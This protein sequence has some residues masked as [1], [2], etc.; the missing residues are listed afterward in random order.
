MRATSKKHARRKEGLT[1][2]PPA[3]LVSSKAGTGS[4]RRRGIVKARDVG[5]AAPVLGVT[6]E[7]WVDILSSDELGAVDVGLGTG[8]RCGVNGYR[9]EKQAIQSG[10]KNGALGDS[11]KEISE[12]MVGELELDGENGTVIDKYLSIFTSPMRMKRMK[13]EKECEPACEI[14]QETPPLSVIPPSLLNVEQQHIESDQAVRSLDHPT[15]NRTANYEADE[16]K[17]PIPAIEDEGDMSMIGRTLHNNRYQ[18]LRILGKGNFSTTYLAEDSFFGPKPLDAFNIQ[19]H[20]SRRTGTLVAIKRLDS[21]LLTTM[22]QAE[23]EILHSLHT[24]GSPRHIIK[25]LSA[26]VD[27]QNIFNLVLES[28]DS[29]RPV[30]LSEGCSC[31]LTYKKPCTSMLACPGRQYTFQKLI[32]QFLSGLHDLHRH[33]LIHADLTPANVLYLPE[34]NRIKIIDLGNV[35]REEDAGIGGEEE[36][37]LQS[38]HYR[39]PEILLGAGPVERGIDVWGAGMVGLE[40]LLGNEGRRR[41]EEDLSLL[42]ENLSIDLSNT[43]EPVMVTAMPS[44]KAMV[45]RLIKIFGSAKMYQNGLYWR[46]EYGHMD[47]ILAPPGDEAARDEWGLSPQRSNNGI[48]GRFL[49]D[50]TLSSGLATFMGKMLAVDFQQRMSVAEI[51]RDHWLVEGLLGEWGSI[52]IGDGVHHGDGVSDSGLIISRQA[53]VDGE[54]VASYGEEVWV[55]EMDDSGFAE[56]PCHSESKKVVKDENGER[57]EAV[58]LTSGAT[59]GIPLIS[60]ADI[61]TPNIAHGNEEIL[62]RESE[63]NAGSQEPNSLSKTSAKQPDAWQFLATP[64]PQRLAINF[65]D[66]PDETIPFTSPSSFPFTYTRFC[67]SPPL[68]ALFQSPSPE[69]LPPP[70]PPLELQQDGSVEAERERCKPADD[71]GQAAVLLEAK[72]PQTSTPQDMYVAP[73]MVPQWT[74]EQ[75]DKEYERNAYAIETVTARKAEEHAQNPKAGSVENHADGMLE[76]AETHSGEVEPQAERIVLDG[77]EDETLNVWHMD[78]TTGVQSNG[79]DEDDDEV[80]LL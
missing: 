1:K 7:G 44:R 19:Q 15:C 49:F 68:P 17:D 5:E 18:I 45:M 12:Q 69:P 71:T 36:F 52:L 11:I 41:L 58:D 32:V 75:A 4:R 78:L 46:E 76:L 42:G 54:E 22:G 74:R 35:I 6:N 73:D 51:L 48:L 31:C 14:R 62:R 3:S 77:S 80:R 72:P 16:E 60:R 59:R 30:K 56:L 13:V 53:S 26:F 55:K 65:D 79:D 21:E 57:N 47:K 20:S 64:R 29:A 28:L 43:W 10:W 24:Q 38:A 50:E 2:S 70:P 66:L 61:P 25:P 63:V 23:F 40:W 39:A 33:G 67:P 8:R 37:E 27:E 34:S 9:P